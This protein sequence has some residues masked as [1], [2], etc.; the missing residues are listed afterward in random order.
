MLITNLIFAVYVV[1]TVV[2]GFYQ[3]RQI[4]AQTELVQKQVDS[5]KHYDRLCEEYDKLKNTYYNQLYR[6]YAE[7]KQKVVEKEDVG[8]VNVNDGNHTEVKDNRP[9]PRRRK[10]RQETK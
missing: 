9:K 1:V 2:I 5:Q 7:V 10:P 4:K 8:V 6:Q 3:S